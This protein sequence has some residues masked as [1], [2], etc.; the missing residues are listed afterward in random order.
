MLKDLD[1][2]D[3]NVGVASAITSY[4]RMRLWTLID[5]IESK[6]YKVFYCDTDSIITDCHL[7]K[8]PGL[9][10]EYCPDK[11]GDALGSLKNECLDKIKKYN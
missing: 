4:A 9:Q 6:G 3:Y 8:E 1:V 5:D 11:T 10:A 2:N 7:S